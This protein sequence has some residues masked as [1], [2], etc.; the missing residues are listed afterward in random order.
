MITK[1]DIKYFSSLR[2]KKFRKEEKKFLVEGKKLIEESLFSNLKPDVVF[3]TNN[4]AEKNEDIIKQLSDKKYRIEYLKSADFERVSDTNSPQGICGVFPIF[5][6]PLVT[7]EIPKETKIFFLENINDPGNMG[8]IVRSCDWFGINEI[9]L[10]GD[11]VDVFNPK[12]VRS[13]VGSLFRMKFIL[14][15]NLKETFSI[16]KSAGY[17]ILAADMDG[18]NVFEFRYPEKFVICFGQESIGLTEELISG[19]DERI[20]IPRIGKAESLNV[21][22]AASI[23]LSKIKS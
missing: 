9:I 20:T 14:S 21:A 7:E 23:I 3:V 1:S 17:K 22:A 15:K 12:V 10:H 16:L 2:I 5:E 8:T 6:T 11:N 13:T 19:C 4:F 18:K